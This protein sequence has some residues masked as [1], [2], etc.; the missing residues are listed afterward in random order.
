MRTTSIF[1]LSLACAVGLSGCIT[2][3][4]QPTSPESAVVL[5][6][7]DEGEESMKAAMAE[8][9]KVFAAM[10]RWQV[11]AQVVWGHAA[12]KGNGTVKLV[13]T[14][15]G[16][17]FIADFPD[18]F[19]GFLLNENGKA[20][21]GKISADKEKKP[22]SEED[23]RAN[24]REISQWL[25]QVV[26]DDWKPGMGRLF[27]WVKGVRLDHDDRVQ[28]HANSGLPWRMEADG[29]SAEFLTWHM[30]GKY[31]LPAVV[32]FRKDLLVV[33]VTLQNWKGEKDT[34]SNEPLNNGLQVI[35][36]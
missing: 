22:I 25:G 23:E 30:D 21:M 5:P 18:Q 17:G 12:Q 19:H 6:R 24:R 35:V 36:T 29:W 8:R 14:T 2:V 13:E 32:I 10:D 15:T 28:F 3:R 31:P 34:K 20:H 16:A 27:R 7:A 4:V 26:G 33:Q 9:E 11:D 1:C